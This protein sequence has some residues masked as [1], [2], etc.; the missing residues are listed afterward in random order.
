MHNIN[1]LIIIFLLMNLMGCKMIREDYDIKRLI[2]LKTEE[3]Q[4]RVDETKKYKLLNL[5]NE[6]VYHPE[7]SHSSSSDNLSGGFFLLLGG[8]SGSYHTRSDSHGAYTEQIIVFYVQND[9]GNYHRVSLFLNQLEIALTKNKTPFV[10]YR[11]TNKIDSIKEDFS[12]GND[13]RY[14]VHRETFLIKTDNLGEYVHTTQ[15][16]LNLN[17]ELNIKLQQTI[18][19]K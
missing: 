14:K 13:Y 9:E 7:E 6:I 8:I 1:I 16:I 10:T 2:K 4:T 17:K 19:L 12:N 15:P 18:N 3:K 5:I 11:N